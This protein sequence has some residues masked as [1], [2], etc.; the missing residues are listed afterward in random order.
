VPRSWPGNKRAS[1]GIQHRA[2]LGGNIA[3]ASPAGDSLPVL[4]AC[5]AVV[6]V[7]SLAGTRDIP[8]ADFFHGY[9]RLALAPD[10]LIL[11][12][13]L[14]GLPRGARSHFRKVGTRRAQSISKVVMAAV[15]RRDRQGRFDHARLAFGSVA[16]VPLRA[17]RAEQALLGER[18]TPA[19]ADAAR[20]ALMDGIT[21]I[22]DI[23]SDAAYR[24][25]VAGNLLAMVL[26][27]EAAGR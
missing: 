18:P 27:A 13:T 11:S 4:L 22:D 21:P 15:L 19:I 8:A 23:R 5:D 12:V 9:K 3:N 25:A 14:P 6:R 16:S 20:A 7:G 17:T 24:R 1:P 2:T 26:R 10:E